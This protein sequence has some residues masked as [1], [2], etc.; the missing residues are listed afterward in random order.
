MDLC[1]RVETALKPGGIVESLR[2]INNLSGTILGLHAR[3]EVGK[4]EESACGPNRYR[5]RGIK[6]KE[7]DTW[8]V[9]N[10]NIGSDVQLGETR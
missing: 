10:P 4:F 2:R 3:V 8:F 6:A 9:L 7:V 1:D 5:T